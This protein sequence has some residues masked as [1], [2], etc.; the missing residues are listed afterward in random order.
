MTIKERVVRHLLHFDFKKISKWDK[1]HHAV[2]RKIIGKR[3]YIGIEIETSTNISYKN[4]CMLIREGF[5]FSWVQSSGFFGTVRYYDGVRDRAAV[6]NSETAVDIFKRLHKD[7]HITSYEVSY[8]FS[9]ND[10]ISFL[11]DLLRVY[12]LLLKVGAQTNSLHISIQA[13]N[14]VIYEE[15]RSWWN[16][17]AYQKK[18]Y[19][20]FVMV[21]PVVHKNLGNNCTLVVD[22]KLSENDIKRYCVIE[23]K[24]N[25]PVMCAASIL[26][27]MIEKSCSIFHGSLDSTVISPF[28]DNIR[29]KKNRFRQGCISHYNKQKKLFEEIQK[30]CKDQFPVSLRIVHYEKY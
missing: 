1:A 7:S 28:Y 17:K 22:E 12:N 4:A 13:P 24:R 20:P 21:S 30:I 15:P 16:I 25:F 9:V 6:N 29:A 11:Q 2:F 3:R 19:E 23:F 14:T 18:Y 26:T 8:L 27:Q 5:R 10:P